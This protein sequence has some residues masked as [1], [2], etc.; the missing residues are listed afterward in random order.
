MLMRYAWYASTKTATV[1]LSVIASDLCT[2][3]TLLLERLELYYHVDNEKDTRLAANTIFENQT[4][5]KAWEVLLDK[6]NK[7]NP[8]AFARWLDTQEPDVMP[9]RDGLVTFTSMTE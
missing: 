9:I 4:F 6:D 8:E 1:R 5:V 2:A 3:K 7:F